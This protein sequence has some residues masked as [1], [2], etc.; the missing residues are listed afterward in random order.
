MLHKYSERGVVMVLKRILN[1]ARM[2]YVFLILHVVRDHYSL[3]KSV[4]LIFVV[5]CIMLL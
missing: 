1:A 5:P 4:N 3:M 2:L